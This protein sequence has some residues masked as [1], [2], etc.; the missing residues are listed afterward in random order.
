MDIPCIVLQGFFLKKIRRGEAQTLAKITSILLIIAIVL[1]L[2]SVVNLL[3]TKSTVEYITPPPYRIIVF[4]LK[5]CQ[6][7]INNSVFP[8]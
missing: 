4:V 1:S 3:I 8:I 5:Q 2:T 6:Q 7:E